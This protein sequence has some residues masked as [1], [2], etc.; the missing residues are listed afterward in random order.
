MNINHTINHT[1]FYFHGV[2]RPQNIKI[3]TYTILKNEKKFIDRFLSWAKECD[4]IWLLDTGSTDGSYEYLC[5]LSK[6]PEWKDKLFIKQ[7]I[8]NPWHFGKAR[9][10]N[11]KMIPPVEKGGPHIL[12]QVD[13][14]E[15]MVEGWKQ[16]F[17]KAAFEHQD[18]ERLTYLYAWNHDEEGN[19]KRVFVYNKC[20]H[21]D[22]RYTTKGAVHEW[23]EWNS[24]CACPYS[25]NYQVSQTKIY[26]HHFPD[27]TKSRG[28]YLG[29]L[30]QRV[31][32]MPDDLNAYAYLWREY[33][34]YGQWENMLKTATHLYIKA[35]QMGNATS[36]LMTNTAYGI[37]MA[38]DKAGLIEEAE[39]FYKRAIEF[40][41]RL[42]DNYMRYA[43]FLV[44]HGRPMEALNIL[45]ESKIKS[46]RLY[47]WRE[48]DYYWRDWKESQIKAGA[49]CWLGDYNLAL[50][51]IHNGLQDIITETDKQ[52]AAS[53]G[54]YS[55]Y[56]FIKN[57]IKK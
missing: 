16:D 34:F 38:Y 19:P 10:E 43:Q 40:E 20:H 42:K 12:I 27:Q 41:P 52:E 49:Y 54:F 1:K 45:K 50:S 5:E 18:F 36:D 35:K 47:D 53:E 24:P 21:N 51:E 30:E 8:F 44:Y 33:S 48:V 56:E 9:T 28:S 14:D 15:V 13:L 25:G 11:M 46:K 39:F 37:A 31:K 4:G 2:L 17:Q 26:K 6:E 3:G 23:I 29:L 22:S 32:E 57:K 7:E 55:D